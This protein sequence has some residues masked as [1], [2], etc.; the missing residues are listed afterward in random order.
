MPLTQERTDPRAL[1]RRMIEGDEDAW[2]EFVERYRSDLYRAIGRAP[3]PD[4]IY[5]RVLARLVERDYAVLR[6]FQ[7]RCSLTTYLG[8]IVR[9]EKIR[10]QH[11]RLIDLVHVQPDADAVESVRAALDRLPMRDRRLLQLLF[12]DGVTYRQ[13]ARA[14][15]V[16]INSVGPLV[17]RALL[18]LK[19]KL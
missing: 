13:A 11:R 3:E 10:G 16:S 17:G 15:G 7:W 5:S 14:L 4:E 12:F 6:R 9:S 8:W 1:V 2:K 18:R 19:E